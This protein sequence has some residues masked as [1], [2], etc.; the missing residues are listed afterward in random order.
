MLTDKVLIVTG[1]GSGI[2][3][4]TAMILAKS[5]ARLVLAGHEKASIE[6]AAG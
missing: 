1:A 4:A 5:G 6:A 2:G 3:L